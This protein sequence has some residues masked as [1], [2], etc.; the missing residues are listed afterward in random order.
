[1]KPITPPTRPYY[2][3]NL[4]AQW[5]SVDVGSRHGSQRNTCL[6]NALVGAL[7]I[8]GRVVSET[9]VKS[10]INSL[11]SRNGE[12]MSPLD[13]SSTTPVMQLHPCVARFIGAHRANLV[14]YRDEDEVCAFCDARN[15]VTL[16]LNLVQYE[17][18]EALVDNR[19]YMAA[20]A[21]LRQEAMDHALARYLQATF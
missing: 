5:I 17:H 19:A 9:S 15:D 11:R 10:L 3:R 16:R 14:L 7:S 13:D 2:S 4:A 8:E 21:R 12:Y 1:M 6:A 18:W 20:R